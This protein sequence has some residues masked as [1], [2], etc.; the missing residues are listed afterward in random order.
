[1]RWRALITCQA[2]QCSGMVSARVPSQSKIKALIM[3]GPDKVKGKENLFLEGSE[4]LLEVVG[5]EGLDQAVDLPFQDGRQIV[6]RQL[7]PVIRDTVL[8]KVVGPDTLVA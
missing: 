4:L 2:R 5:H 7:D 6:E 3:E 8:G 1:M